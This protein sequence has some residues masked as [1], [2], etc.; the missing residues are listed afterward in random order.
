MVAGT[1]LA[2]VYSIT[3][4]P[5]AQADKKATAEAYKIV[6]SEADIF[7]ELELKEYRPRFDK[8]KEDFLND[9]EMSYK[10]QSIIKNFVPMT[11]EGCVVRISDIIAYI[12][13][14]IEDAIR[15]NVIKK[16]DIDTR[17]TYCNTFNRHL[18]F[19][20]RQTIRKNAIRKKTR[21]NLKITTLQRRKI[22]KP[23]SYSTIGRRYLNAKSS[24]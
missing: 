6:C 13:R 14:D 8:T 18:Y 12:G 23:Q 22:S 2:F 15:M 20:A 21:K 16:D 5:I 10:D 9:Y 17:Y 7:N 1:A 4:E 24:L 3:K 19:Y 11:L